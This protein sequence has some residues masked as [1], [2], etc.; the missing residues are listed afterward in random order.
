MDSIENKCLEIFK[1]VEWSKVGKGEDYDQ[2]VL[3][4]YEFFRRAIIF[5]KAHNIINEVPWLIIAKI[6][7]ENCYISEETDKIIEG[8][9]NE[10]DGSGQR[11]FI[12]PALL[13]Y[14][15][16]EKAKELGVLSREEKNI[17][18]PLLHMFM[19]N[20]CFHSHHGYI[21]F[22]DL[23]QIEVRN[24]EWMGYYQ[25]ERYIEFDEDF[26]K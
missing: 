2:Y 3:L 9:A 18:A 5:A 11:W 13:G 26:D 1:R 22:N 20:G 23:S 15:L 8:F 14:T 12:L 21:E 19:I 24:Y 25:A 10:T 7:P 17:Y 4:L 16:F 6:L